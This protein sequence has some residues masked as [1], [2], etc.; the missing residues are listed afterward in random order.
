MPRA[1]VVRRARRNVVRVARAAGSRSALHS[2]HHGARRLFAI[3]HGARRT[4]V[5]VAAY[6]ARRS[7]AIEHGACRIVVIVAAY[8][9]RHLVR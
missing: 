1:L 6:V 4:L 5:I 9:A 8:V 7:C 3:E 2:S